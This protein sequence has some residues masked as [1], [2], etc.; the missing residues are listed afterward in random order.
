MPAKKNIR[1]MQPLGHLFSD[2]LHQTL[3]SRP[4]ALATFFERSMTPLDFVVMVHSENSM[5]QIWQFLAL[6]EGQTPRRK[7][8]QCNSLG[9]DHLGV[10]GL[11]LDMFGCSPAGEKLK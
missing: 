1:L 3:I 6:S 8:C 9:E 2:R 5:L 11:S 10:L 7:S 4:H